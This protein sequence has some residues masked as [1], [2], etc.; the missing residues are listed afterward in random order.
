MCG[1]AGLLTTKLHGMAEAVLEKMAMAMSHR[2]PDDAG[3]HLMPSC[4]GAYSVGLIHRRLS[5]IDLSPA[6]HQPMLDPQTGNWI[7][8]NGEIYNFQHIRRELQ[9]EEH[10]FRSQTD[11]EVIL[12]AYARDGVECLQRFRGMFALAIWDAQRQHLFMA[13]D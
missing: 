11:T 1:I 7:V 4:N 9:G 5:I 3:V 12:K 13:R 2:G 6:G 10:T 8:F